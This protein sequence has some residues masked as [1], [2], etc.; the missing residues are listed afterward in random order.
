MLRP[1]VAHKGVENNMLVRIEAIKL[2]ITL[3]DNF[4]LGAGYGDPPTYADDVRINKARWWNHSAIAWSL[5]RLGFILAT[6]FLIVFIKFI[7]ETFQLSNKIKDGF[8]RNVLI[9]IGFYFISLFGLAT[10]TNNF[11]R[12]DFFT[13]EIAICLGLVLAIENLTLKGEI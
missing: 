10:G 9:G 13:M 7:Y 5:Y 2:A 11:F 6:G 1:E 4:F 12:G 8:I 3:T